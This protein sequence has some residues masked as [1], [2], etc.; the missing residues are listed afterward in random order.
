LS[1]GILVGEADIMPA[2]TTVTGPVPAE[3]LGVTTIH[4]HLLFDASWIH[5][6]PADPSLWE[7]SE[8]PLRMETLGWARKFGY[9]HRDNAERLD[10]DEAIEEIGFFK[11]AGGR[12]VVDQTPSW[13]LGRDPRA[14][15]AIARATGLNVVM[16]CGYYEERR[17]PASLRERGVEEIAAELIAEL[18]IGVGE[19]GVRAGIIG[20]IGTSER[21]TAEEEKVLRAAA[22]AQAATGVALSIHHGVWGR[23]APRA[24]AIAKSEGADPRRTLICHVDLDARCELA[25]YE[26]I[27]ATGAYLGFDTFG[28][29]EIYQ[30]G[31]RQ[32]PGR[33][34]PT[35]YERAEK[36]A[37]LVEAGYLRQI[38]LAQDLLTKVQLRR[39][40]GYGFDHLLLSVV[41]MFRA[42]GLDERQIQMLLVDNPARLLAG[43]D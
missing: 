20:E 8:A 34:Y 11:R 29:V 24:L 13:G 35:D 15:R 37:A 12:T 36:V 22:R 1:G 3:H 31:G 26:E 25:Y 30:Y 43:C 21:F 9:D 27:A 4:E 18:T 17:H 10:V 38:V 33:V 39:Y 7:I 42:L 23:H 2:V 6:P 19:T 41:P 14:L 32:R 28:Q 5:R 40:G 16:G